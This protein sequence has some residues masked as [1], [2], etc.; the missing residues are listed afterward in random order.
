MTAQPGSRNTLIYFMRW[1]LLV[2]NLGE[3]SKRLKAQN[4][5][6]TS[7]LNPDCEVE[8]AE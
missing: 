8:T 5:A 3:F 4:I 2:K 1:L 6:P 7:E